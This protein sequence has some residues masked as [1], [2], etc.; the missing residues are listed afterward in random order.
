MTHRLI[1]IQCGVSE[2]RAALVEDGS[3]VEFWFGP[4]RA[5]E[6]AETGPAIGRVYRGKVI[7]T[8][9]RLNAAFVDIGEATAGFTPLPKGRR[10][11]EGA[12]V[13]VAV[14]RTPRGEKGATLT[15]SEE[16][17]VAGD[18]GPLAPAIDAA[19]QAVRAFG[20]SAD[21]IL[22]D[23]G[24]A[25]A[26]LVKHIPDYRDRIQVDVAQDIFAEIGAEE[27]LEEAFSVEVQLTAGGSV[28]IEETEALTAIDVNAGDHFSASAARL[29]EK[30]NLEAARMIARQVR[31]RNIGGVIAID[32][33]SMSE[34]K[35]RTLNAQLRQLLANAQKAGWSSSGLFSFILPRPD[36]SLL[37]RACE[38]ALTDPAPGKRFTLR[39]H[40]NQFL[41]KAESLL[42]A[43]PGESVTAYLGEE[44]NSYIDAH[45]IW[46]LRLAE[47][48][49][50]RL[51][52]EADSKLKGR[53]FAF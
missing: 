53:E 19:V 45:P 12:V 40:A 36:L 11:S 44:L 27:T 30:I 13:A 8:D 17:A 41:H 38:P 23:K 24:D 18:V 48:Y 15:L 52:F 16:C 14:R 7:K 35:R 2:T 49:G 28:T 22:I 20:V 39:F 6:E 34:K 21:K 10:L 29:R 4:A 32:F 5:D 51:K 26:A 37:E 31:L 50:A 3:V 47:I 9:D 1:A 43:S 42:R 33:L 46:R 25:K